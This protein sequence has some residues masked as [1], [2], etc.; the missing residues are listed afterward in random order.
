SRRRSGTGD[1]GWWA[2]ACGPASSA[3]EDLD[4]VALGEGDDGPL[5]GGARAVTT[6]TPVAL[7]LALAVQ[8][9][10]V[11]DPHVEDGLDRVSDLDLVGVAGDDERVD[12]PHECGVRLLGHHRPDDDVAGVLVAH[13]APASWSLSLAAGAPGT[14]PSGSLGCSDPK[15]ATAASSVALLKTSQSLT[16]TS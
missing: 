13:A 4:R 3:P 8:R 10:H 16:S 14:T 6:R 11:G 15:R 5:G 1:R 2:C 9:V 12:V 7:A